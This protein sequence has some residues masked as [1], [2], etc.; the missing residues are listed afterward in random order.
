MERIFHEFIPLY[1][2]ISCHSSLLRTFFYTCMLKRLKG[3]EMFFKELRL[4]IAII[5]NTVH[6]TSSSS[7]VTNPTYMSAY[8]L[9]DSYI[10]FK[11]KQKLKKYFYHEYRKHYKAIY[12]MTLTLA[13]FT[14]KKDEIHCEISFS[15]PHEFCIINS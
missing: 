11:N 5:P 1:V 4:F 10:Y 13:H 12:G 2:I 8:L 6:Y 9:N 7:L 14:R 15:G 3:L